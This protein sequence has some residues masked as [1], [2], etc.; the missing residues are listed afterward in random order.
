MQPG[1]GGNTKHVF[2]CCLIKKKVKCKYK[3][4]TKKEEIFESKDSKILQHKV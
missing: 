1:Q 2:I 3:I 4:N